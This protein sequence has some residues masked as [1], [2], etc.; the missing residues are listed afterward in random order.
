LRRESV[1]VAIPVAMLLGVTAIWGWTFLIVKDAVHVYPVGAFLGLRFVLAAILLTP[2][3]VRGISWPS[4][5]AG[6]FIGGPLAAGYLFQTIG[7]TDTSAANAGLLTGLFV[8]LTPLV[9]WLIFRARAPWI[10]V[11]AAAVGVAGTGLLTAGS[12]HGLRW[13]D[14]LEVLTALSFA[15][16]IVLLARVPRELPAGQVA[17]GQIVLAAGAFSVLGAGTASR[18]GL[19]TGQVLTAVLI[20]AVLASAL[21]FWIQ[22]WVQQ[23]LSASRT[24]IILLGEPA[25]AA[26]FAVWLGGERLDAVQWLGAALI[27]L[28]LLGHET[29][30]AL[31]GRSSIQP[32]MEPTTTATPGTA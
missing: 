12:V 20:T 8:V 28:A 32:A 23:R 29:V 19:P 13:G 15:L 14:V 9:D 3:F 17:F 11:V 22:T 30:L 5:R 27:L 21:A 10:T 2:V 24:A 6:L 4:L 25:F 1:A 26:G 18:A 31:T 7:L 16:Q